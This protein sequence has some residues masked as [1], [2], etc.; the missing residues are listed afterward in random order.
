[1]AVRRTY[2]KLAYDGGSR[3]WVATGLEPHVIG[4]LKTIFPR[5]PLTQVDDFRFP[6]DP[7]NCTELLWFIDRYPLSISARDLGLLRSGRKSFERHQADLERIL[8]PDWTPSPLAGIREGQSVRQYQSQGAEVCHR[9]GHLLLG[10]DVGLGK[11]YSAIALMLMPGTLPAAVVVEPHLQKQWAEKIEQFCGLRVHCVTTTKPYSLPEAD[12]YIYR[13]SNVFGWNAVFSKGPFRTVVYDEVQQLRTG[14][15]TAKGSAC[16][17]LSRTATYRL[18]MSATP[19][20]NMGAEIYEIMHFMRPDEHVLGPRD[21]FQREWVVSGTERIKD[22]K[23]LGAYLRERYLL[24]RRTKG[25]VGQQM[26]R[27]NT[28]P[29]EIPYDHAAGKDF[30]ELARTLA[31]KALSAPVFMERGRAAREFD[32]LMRQATGIAKAR[33]VAAYVRILV[34]GGRKVLLIGWHRAVYDIWLRDLK[35]LSPAM[36]TG[37]E[38]PAQKDRT[39]RAFVSGETDL[40]IMSLRSGSGLDGLQDVCSTVVF[41]ELDWSPL[42]HHQIVGRLDRE[43]QKEDTVDA[44]FLHA[45]DGSDPAM[46]ELLGIKASQS[47]GIMDPNEGVTTSRSEVGRIQH[48]A[49]EYLKRKGIAVEERVEATDAL[50]VDPELAEIERQVLAEMASKAGGAQPRGTTPA[51]VPAPS[52]A[53][54]LFAELGV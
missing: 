20:F 6:S 39:K 53:P 48:L 22:P 29:E 10:D 40:L 42:V 28:I 51:T 54:D 23:A 13:Y 4:R 32:L 49:R 44:F 27:V 30:E 50:D 33:S 24:I 38:S 35:D 18:L 31:I 36:F 16:Q 15:S 5:I 17:H 52:R 12:V 9:N 8:T 47:K 43:G 37:T 11:T 1:M 41:G 3:I 2:G 46:I 26:D 45:D 25:D 19:I 34:E 7:F 21:E 14:A